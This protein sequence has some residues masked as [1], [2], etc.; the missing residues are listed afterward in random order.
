MTAT[1][2]TLYSHP[3]S[4][5][6]HRA[7][8]ALSLMEVP[9]ITKNIDLRAREQRSDWFL[10]LNAAG[11]VPVLIDG[12]LILPES[13]AILVYLAEKYGKGMWL[14]DDA[15]GRA[16]VQRWLYLASTELMAGPAAARRI[17][18]FGAPLDV[19]ETREKADAFLTKLDRALEGRLW[20]V[21]ESA[22]IADLA[23]YSY[24]AH[25]PEGG[26]SLAPYSNVLLWLERVEALERF[27]PMQ[28][29]HVEAA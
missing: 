3:L 20:L 13:T 18:L 5:H 25:A 2:L 19:A 1:P 23:H 28:R 15:V 14:P 4:G 17:V 9:Y 8:L 21:G 6:A 12:D 24:V 10:K 29:T 22:T 27:V 26:V 7:A 11:L 16:Q